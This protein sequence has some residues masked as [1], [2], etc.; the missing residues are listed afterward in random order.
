MRTLKYFRT[1]HD[2]YFHAHPLHAT[3]ALI[4]SFLL[5]AVV[6]LVLVSSAR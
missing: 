5:A 2:P 4:A 6:V 3:F 1:H